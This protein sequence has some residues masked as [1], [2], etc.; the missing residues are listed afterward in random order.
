MIRILPLL[1]YY[2]RFCLLSASEI[3]FLFSVIKYLNM[4]SND[5]KIPLYINLV[6][7]RFT[8]L[9]KDFLRRAQLVPLSF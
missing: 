2:I 7:F 8:H 1:L 4:K 5:V 9:F 3:T 6:L